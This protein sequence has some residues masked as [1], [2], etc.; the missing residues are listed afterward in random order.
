MGAAVVAAMLA[1]AAAA[2]AESKYAT[3]TTSAA[4]NFRSATGPLKVSFLQATTDKATGTAKFYCWNQVA[5]AKPVTAPTNNQSV[6]KVVNTTWAYTNADLVVY[7]H[8]D[9]TVDYR[10]VSGATTGTVTLSSGVSQ[11]GTTG[12]RLFELTQGFQ[13]TVGSLGIGPTTN[14]TL[15]AANCYESP[16]GSPLRIVVDGTAASTCAATVQR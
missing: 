6:I 5:V 11:A 7:E 3:G 13:L 4:V 2:I 1:V 16:G 14:V 12:D 10:T 8:T 9:G 15:E